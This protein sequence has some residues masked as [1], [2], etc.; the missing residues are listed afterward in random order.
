MEDVVS[1]REPELERDRLDLAGRDALDRFAVSPDRFVDDVAPQQPTL[2]RLDVRGGLVTVDPELE[3]SRARG[4][5]VGGGAHR[6]PQLNAPVT[7]AGAWIPPSRSPAPGRT[8]PSNRIEV[9]AP[10]PP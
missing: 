10:S 3:V 4:L 9:A 6:R 7:S 5:L 8:T 1:G 2:D